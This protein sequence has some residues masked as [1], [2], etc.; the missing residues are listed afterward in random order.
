MTTS[1]SRSRKAVRFSSWFAIGRDST[2][3]RSQ[4]LH[5]FAQQSSSF[6]LDAT[7]LCAASQATSL[8]HPQSL[9]SAAS[10]ATLK[11]HSAVRS[12]VVQFR[13]F[14]PL[15]VFGRRPAQPAAP[16]VIGRFT[17]RAARRD[18]HES[19]AIEL[20]N[21]SISNFVSVVC[22]ATPGELA[23]SHATACSAKRFSAEAP[24]TGTM[25]LNCRNAASLAV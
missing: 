7:C 23:N 9:P 6:E 15:E 18:S 4:V 21:L 3:S 24:S 13:R 16:A 10:A 11:S 20:Q 12:T 2:R 8:L 5:Q 25:T 14:P 22:W 19:R 17:V 1:V